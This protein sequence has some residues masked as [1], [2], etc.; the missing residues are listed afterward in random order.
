MAPPVPELS[1]PLRLAILD[2]LSD[3]VYLV[4]RRRQIIYWNSGAERL[5]GYTAEEAIGRRCQDHRLNRCDTHGTPL[6]GITCPLLDTMR[7]GEHREAHVFLSHKDGSRRPVWVR[8]TPLRDTTG[9]IIGTV[10]IFNDDSAL[11]ESRRRADDLH[12]S[13]M[14]DALT[15]LGNRRKGAMTLGAWLTQ[16]RDYDWPF[17]ALLCDVDHFKAV[18][19]CHGHHAGDQALRLIAHTLRNASRVGDEIVRWG[20]EEFLVLAADTTPATLGALGERLRAL[21]A[22]SRLID[23]GAHVPLT[24]SIGATVAGPDDT[25]DTII[26]RADALLYRAKRTGRNRVCVDTGLAGRAAA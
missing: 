24:L 25:P 14:T 1:Q 15:G 5:T 7:D 13:A 6:C 12:H 19:D 20:G 17:A 23:A 3:G 18:N 10:G 26:R 21:V 22:D 8:A 16:R 9:L 2:S 11:V 4:D